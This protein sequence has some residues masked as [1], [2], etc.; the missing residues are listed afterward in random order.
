MTAFT[1]YTDGACLGNPGPGGW[2]AILVE[3][4]HPRWWAGHEDH[5]TNNRMEIM[6]VIRGL[7]QT[8]P[9]SAVTVHS[10]S[11]Y[12]INTFVK[13]WQTKANLDLWQRLKR[14]VAERKVDWQWVRGHNGD[15]FNE[16]ADHLA[17]AAAADDTWGAERDG[18][19]GAPAQPAAPPPAPA[20]P[21]QA[22]LLPPAEPPVAKP[23]LPAAAPAPKPAPPAA[24][25]T[26]APA[27]SHL[28]A[29]GNARMV[30]V[31]E[32]A[33]THREAVAQGTVHMQ[34]ATLSLIQAGGVA[35]GDVFTVAQVAGVM[36]A[37]RT[38]DLIPL[39]HPLPLTLV[40]LRFEPDAAN[41]CV[42]LT[43]TVRTSAQTGVEME[44]LTAVSVAALTIYDMCKAADRGMRIGDIRV[45]HKAGGK[46]GA[47]DQ[48]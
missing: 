21:T 8:P 28:D 30:D 31:S 1:L 3:S 41:A 37:K 24:T 18:R 47:F 16:E 7:E 40:D 9:G 17:T 20:G 27:L 43:A 32:K 44:A 45:T 4:P 14:L 33:V 35:K 42:H 12:V 19:L 13:H 10:D 26:P 48:P 36:A 29:E 25:P 6:G 11:Q 34:P 15:T 2:A 23:A 22:T 38:A 5:T 46:S 39:C